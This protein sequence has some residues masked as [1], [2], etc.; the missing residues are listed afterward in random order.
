VIVSHLVLAAC[1]VTVA[2]SFAR[3]Y[4][5]SAF[6][7]TLEGRARSVAALVYYRDDGTPGLLFGASK[8]PPSSHTRHLDFYDVRSNYEDFAVHTPGYDPRIF[9]GVPADRQFWDF[10]YDKERYRAIILR[11]VAILDT[12]EGIPNPPPTLT[13]FYAIPSEDISERATALAISIAITSL[14]LVIPT[15]SLAVWIIR[16][17]VAPLHRL[18][19]HAGNISVRNWEFNPSD[20]ERSVAELAPLITALETVLSGLKRAFTRQREFLGDAAHELKTSFAIVKSSLQSLLNVPRTAAEYRE[21]LRQLSEDSDRLEELLDR[22]LRLA[23]VEQ[24]AADGVRRDLEI[25]DMCSTCEMA[26]ARIARLAAN[27]D[28]RIEVSC[29]SSAQLRAD[30]ADLELVWMNLLENAVQYSNPRSTV[31]LTSFTEDQ[32]ANVVVADTGCGI[33]G[34]DL[35][36]IFERFRRSDPSRSRATGGYGLGLAMAKSIVEAYGGS[37]R[38]T[39]TPGSGTKISVTLPVIASSIG[40][41]TSADDQLVSPK[42]TVP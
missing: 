7:V 40:H 39:S 2:T 30:P 18:A 24:W 14:L 25:T 42:V 6:D 9:D 36:H 22:M 15:L 17:S 23:R 38:A 27:R 31:T 41:R 29:D 1:L 33:A 3:R 13:V 32:T 19:T 20:A 28:I 8:I 16:R 37:I 26:V 4:L 5:Q 34:T 11:N 12:E 10:T 35:P 21:G